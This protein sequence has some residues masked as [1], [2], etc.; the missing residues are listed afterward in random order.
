MCMCEGVSGCACVRVCGC[1]CVR[2]CGYE[3]VWVCMCEGVSG[4]ILG[5][6]QLLSECSKPLTFLGSSPNARK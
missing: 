1:A 6:M 2:A 4:C 5:T 3:G